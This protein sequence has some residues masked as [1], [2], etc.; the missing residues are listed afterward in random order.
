MVS[1][2]AILR[3]N[4]DGRAALREGLRLIGNI[5]D[6]N[7]KGRSVVIKPGIYDHKKRNHPEVS[8]V[9]ALIDS[10]S[11]APQVYLVESENYKGKALERL[12]IYKETFTKR[13]VP[14]DLS[15]DSNT[16]EAGIANEK[17]S[18]SHVLFKPNV[19]V[20]V[21]A[22]RVYE[23]GT[24]LKNLLGLIPERKKVR[25]HKKLGEVLLDVYE[26]IGGIDLAVL[27]G[28]YTYPRPALDKRVKTNVLLVGKDAIAVEA[29]GAT[30]V[31]MDPEKILVI[32]EAM[33]RGLGEGD[34]QRIE[35]LGEPVETAK[36]EVSLKLKAFKH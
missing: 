33:R 8:V 5:G 26:A 25:F 14:V 12:Q 21:H 9:S 31:G 11:L 29:I 27:D 20:S 7:T 23:K 35:V 36:K 22:L 28:T 1:K 2:V 34:L 16:D 10:F 3:L 17:M 30:L 19:F 15:N 24:I 6:L 32:R 13:V 18:L 4:G